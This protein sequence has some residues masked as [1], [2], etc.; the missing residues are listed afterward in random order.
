MDWSRFI[1]GRLCKSEVRISRLITMVRFLFCGMRE[2]DFH[3][4]F[5]QKTFTSTTPIG[6]IHAVNR[7]FGMKANRYAVCQRM[8]LYMLG[9]RHLYWSAS[10]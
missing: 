1:I 3:G 6:A 2:L 9:I 7:F 10:K 4:Q 5:G 8:V